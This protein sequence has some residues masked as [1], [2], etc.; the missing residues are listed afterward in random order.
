MKRVCSLAVL[1]CALL[2]LGWC[3]D[4]FAGATIAPAYSGSYTLT[5]LGPAGNIPK[6]VFT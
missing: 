3:S 4:L 2:V 1:G 5:D 6:W